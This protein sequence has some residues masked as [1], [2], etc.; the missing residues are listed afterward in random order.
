[1]IDDEGEDEDIQLKRLLAAFNVDDYLQSI[2]GTDKHVVQWQNCDALVLGD[3]IAEQKLTQ[4]QREKLVKLLVNCFGV[5]LHSQAPLFIEV[6]SDG[7]VD[8]KCTVQ[9]DWAK[10]I[11]H[12]Y[13]VLSRNWI[14]FSCGW[15]FNLAYIPLFSNR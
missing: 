11:K 14:L 2:T 7:I 4:S 9:L 1:M 8:L 5:H 10:S 13:I 12:N 6:K 15:Q 3:L